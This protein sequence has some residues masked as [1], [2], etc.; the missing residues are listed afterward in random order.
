M[1]VLVAMTGCREPLRCG[2]THE[3]DES[4]GRCVCRGGAL[5]DDAGMCGAAT[6]DAGVDPADGAAGATDAGLCTAEECDGVDQDCDDRVDESSCGAAAACVDL[7]C[8]PLPIHVR[9]GALGRTSATQIMSLAAS[10]DGF[11]IVGFAR[12]EDFGDGAIAGESFVAFFGRDG[13]HRWSH[14]L[15]SIDGAMRP[16]AVV[17]RPDGRVV[18]AGGFSGRTSA[19]GTPEL[20]AGERQ[21]AFVVEY[22]TL[23]VPQVLRVFDA[24]SGGGIGISA[25][26]LAEDGDLIVAGSFAG[27]V[28]LATLVRAQGW[29]DVFIARVSPAGALE[30]ARP[31]GGDGDEGL[32]SVAVDADGIYAAGYFESALASFGGPNLRNAGQVDGFVVALTHEGLHRWTTHIA[33]LDD[34]YATAV[35]TTPGMVHVAGNVGSPTTTIGDA[36]LVR[37]GGFDLYVAGLGPSDG[38]VAW[39]SRYGSGEVTPPLLASVGGEVF[40]GTAFTQ[41]ISVGGELLT[42]PPTGFAVLIAGY[43]GTT[44][45]HQWSRSYPARSVA[46]LSATGD[47]IV[48]GGAFSGEVSLGGEP[49]VAE[50]VAGQTFWAEYSVGPSR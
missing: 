25:M 23:G 50:P 21:H 33:G 6:D 45:V 34:D 10:A 13:G 38:A 22:S 8:E 11:A 26:A 17:V 1:V 18:I 43:D 12:D 39:A 5:A 9:S 4:L 28:N 2:T 7:R 14:S 24:A 49:I 3:Y 20:V 19:F 32:V 37:R 46:G 29:S 47:R 31:M 40:V 30:W 27:D 44:G 16:R 41:A 35:V 48:V 42:A 36:E 15:S